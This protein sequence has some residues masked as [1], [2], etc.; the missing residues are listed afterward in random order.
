MDAKREPTSNSPDAR[1]RRIRA[2]VLDVPD[3]PAM[4]VAYAQLLSILADERATP[5]QLVEIL[6]LDP[7]LAGRVLR[8]ANSAF[9]GVPGEVSSLNRAVLLLGWKWVSNLALGVSVWSSFTD[10]GGTPAIRLWGHA[11]RVAL[12]ARLLARHLA[13]QDAESAFSAG[14]LHD[15]G[16]AVLAVRDREYREWVAGPDRDHDLTT[17]RERFGVD[18]TMVGRWL[19][20]SWSLPAH[21]VDSIALHHEPIAPD[22]PADTL[23]VVRLADRL[24]HEAECEDENDAVLKAPFAAAIE[25]LAPG[26]GLT[27]AWPEI[28][29]TVREEGRD[30]EQ[31]FTGA[32]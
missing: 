25:A 12:A 27:S 29:A 19:A 13:L 3:V 11:A 31:L 18:H 15:I 23:A 2:S 7:A 8:L 26:R 14:L 6:E 4:P 5:Q 9:L 24:I 22:D 1:M 17:E 28:V 20:T 21:L 30:L 32:G 16:R 10:R